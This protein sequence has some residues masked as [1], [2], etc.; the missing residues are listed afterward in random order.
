[1]RS[2]FENLA[3]FGRSGRFKSENAGRRTFPSVGR[4]VRARA[5]ARSSRGKG[6]ELSGV[7]GEGPNSVRSTRRALAFI[8]KSLNIRAYLWAIAIWHQT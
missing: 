4:W 8:S 3:N 6:S 5:Y 7:V 2:H 1:V